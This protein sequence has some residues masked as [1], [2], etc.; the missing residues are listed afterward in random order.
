M[1]S[2]DDLIQLY[3]MIRGK[4]LYE[5]SFNAGFVTRDGFN[6]KSFKKGLEQFSSK[7][8]RKIPNIY[9]GYLADAYKTIFETEL[10][11]LPLIYNDSDKHMKL[12]IRWRYAVGK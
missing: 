8:I 11:Q 7:F 1:Y 3:D 9:Q 5:N 2:R 12:L 4:G 10:K 6:P